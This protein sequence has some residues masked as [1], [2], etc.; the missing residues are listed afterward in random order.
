MNKD[1]LFYEDSE[2]LINSSKINEKR[3]ISKNISI[4]KIDL[5]KEEGIK[6][7]RPK[8]LYTTIFYNNDAVKDEIEKLIELTTNSIK[9][10]LEY[11]KINKKN[12][13]LFVGIGN[14]NLSVDK[15]GYLLIDK[16]VVSGNTHKIY[17]DINAFTNIETTDFIKSLVKSL[18]IDLV[19]VVDSLKAENIERLGTTIQICTA[20]LKP[21]KNKEISKKTVS[22]KVISIG[23]PT[24]I[25]MKSLS[26]D[27]PSILVTTDKVD[28]I[29]ENNSSILSIAINRLF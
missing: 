4:T 28:E 29:V 6:I 2:V 24:I 26:K 10:S 21:L 5:T 7:N 17:K 15:L 8:G 9:E 22:A 1:N 3:E 19:I 18:G 25:D 23:V 16:I 12:K 11:L 14:K 20:G 13:I 27:N